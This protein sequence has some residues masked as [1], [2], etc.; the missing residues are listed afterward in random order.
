[1]KENIIMNTKF[2]LTNSNITF[3]DAYNVTLTVQNGNVS[4]STFY[5][6]TICL[7]NGKLYN[8]DQNNTQVYYNDNSKCGEYHL[9]A[10]ILLIAMFLIGLTVFG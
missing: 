10:G 6:S 2:E 3:S 1:M 5:N 8:V 4:N 9:G 7:L